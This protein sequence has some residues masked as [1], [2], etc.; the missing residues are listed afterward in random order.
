MNPTCYRPVSVDHLPAS[1]AGS[2]DKDLFH[3]RLT[4]NSGDAGHVLSCV[5]IPEALASHFQQ[6]QVHEFHV[7]TL[8]LAGEAHL[9][10]GTP[11]FV[12]IGVRT[13]DGREFTQIPA[14]VRK[15]ALIRVTGGAMLTILGVASLPSL[16]AFAGGCLALGAL[17]VVKTLQS[18]WRPFHVVREYAPN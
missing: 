3:L 11:R 5:H 4:M 6:R 13:K 16:P 15:A 17:L 2:Q 14:P 12:V 9:L 7:E 10:P 1:W 8:D 18:R